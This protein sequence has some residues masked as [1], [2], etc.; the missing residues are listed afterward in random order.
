M[1]MVSD[2]E[3]VRILDNFYQTSSFYP[4]PVVLITTVSESGVT[5][6]GPYSLVFPFGIAGK[7]AMMLIFRNTSNTAMNVTRTKKAT[8]NFIPFNKRYLKN[9]V[10]LGFP[11][12]TTEEKLD[13]SIFTLIPSDKG[14][15]DIIDEAIEAFEC[16]W[17]D[18]DDFHYNG[19]EGEAHFLLR[20]D[21][22][23]MKKKW[24]EKLVQGNKPGKG[25]GFPSLPID[26]GYRDNQF[27]WFAEHSV[28]YSE[29]LPTGKGVDIGTVRYQADRIDP[30]VT[31]TDEA[32]EKIVAIPRVFLKK[33]MTQ[34]VEQAKDMGHTTIT[35]EVLDI[36]RD[37]RSKEKQL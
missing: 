19:T 12:T 33:A 30:E 14:A 10:R 34:M 18:G 22:I 28:P 25:K 24:K 7:H 17:D 23:L 3:E 27:F 32:C 11:G 8:L 36:I 1:M 26:Y 15:P 37:K 9:T 35:P 5:N 6:I 29:T 4:M 20:I 13:E 21:R 31:W 2:F 16:T